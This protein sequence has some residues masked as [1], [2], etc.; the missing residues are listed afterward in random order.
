MTAGGDKD[1]N[2]VR[3]VSLSGGKDFVMFLGW[4]EGWSGDFGQLGLVIEFR[5]FGERLLGKE[6]LFW[7]IYLLKIV[8]NTESQSTRARS[9]SYINLV[10]CNHPSEKKAANRNKI[11]A[12]K[13]K[14]EQLSGFL[15]RS[16]MS[17]T[18]S[19]SMFR[20]KS[21][22]ML[23]VISGND[24]K[25]IKEIFTKAKQYKDRINFQKVPIKNLPKSN[26]YITKPSRMKSISIAKDSNK[27]IENSN[28]Y[29]FYTWKPIILFNRQDFNTK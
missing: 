23:P 6:W 19:S 27:N 14:F 20:S 12:K 7:I 9:P 15:N 8:M 29:K 4:W 2:D 17:T 10:V 21:N 25:A 28:N 16:K 13:N 5:F 3:E 18:S 1:R 24:L 11:K 26:V 22:H